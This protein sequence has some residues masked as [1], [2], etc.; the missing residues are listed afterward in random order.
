MRCVIELPFHSQ[1][2]ALRQ[3]GSNGVIASQ[4]A[5]PRMNRRAKLGDGFAFRRQPVETPAPKRESHH[6]AF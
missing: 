6:T 1:S 4:L 3:P 2:Q 5:K